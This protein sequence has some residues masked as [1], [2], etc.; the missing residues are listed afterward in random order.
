MWKPNVK[1]HRELKKLLSLSL[2]EMIV[3]G[4]CFFLVGLAFYLSQAQFKKHTEK[5][6]GKTALSIQQSLDTVY[7]IWWFSYYFIFELLWQV[8]VIFSPERCNKSALIPLFIQANIGLNDETNTWQQ[9]RSLVNN[10]GEMIHIK[11]CNLL[12]SWLFKWS[13]YTLWAECK[14]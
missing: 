1:Y 9:P 5:E 13:V 7:N 12:L 2:P 8:W 3:S 10:Q 6:K 4:M 11:G 14:C